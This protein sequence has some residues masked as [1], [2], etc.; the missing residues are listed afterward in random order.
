M[1]SPVG[2]A[3]CLAQTC[4]GVAYRSH[5]RTARQRYRS[6]LPNWPP[7][8]GLERAIFGKIGPAQAPRPRREQTTM[9][10]GHGLA[11]HFRRRGR[12]S[13]RRR[14][15]RA[16]DTTCN[17]PAWARTRSRRAANT[18]GVAEI[19]RHPRLMTWFAGLCEQAAPGYECA[20]KAG[21][22]F[23]SA[24]RWS[25]SLPATRRSHGDARS[26]GCRHN[27]AG[28]R[29]SRRPCAL[30]DA[31]RATSRGRST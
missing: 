2:A 23:L 19:E 6:P 18:V 22:S 25:T 12:Q 3:R 4:A 30:P 24:N 16:L 28:A 9:L 7:T 15:D 1:A 27:F 21:S 11:G 31:F 26:G 20:C 17:P 5:R 10:R 14:P 8:A 13:A 29:P